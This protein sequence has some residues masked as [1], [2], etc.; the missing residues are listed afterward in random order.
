MKINV[1]SIEATPEEVDA[2]TVLSKA[3]ARLTGQPAT[4]VRD[5]PQTVPAEDV[6]ADDAAADRAAAEAA[7]TPAPATPDAIPGVASE[8]QTTVHRL[9]EKNPASELFVEFVAETSSWPHVGVHGIKPKGH[10]PGTALD[11][12]RY[13]RLRKHGSHFG[14]FAYAYA[15][16]GL[17]NLRLAF[18][19]DEELR[20]IAPDAVR[21][22]KGHR[23]YRVNIRVSDE[24]KLKQALELA[25]MAYDAT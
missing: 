16:D 12:S 23:E 19:S 22:H 25:R 9:L 24:S 11:Y 8:G 17:I 7:E 1:I 21:L 13:L 14:G 2:S 10:L 5:H 15:V 4:D 18:E 3:F 20:E 6:D